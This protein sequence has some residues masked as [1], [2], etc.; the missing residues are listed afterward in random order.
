VN[1]QLPWLRI[2]DSALLSRHCRNTP[3]AL[4]GPGQI[5]VYAPDEDQDARWSQFSAEVLSG[6]FSTRDGLAQG[7]PDR[8]HWSMTYPLQPGPL[9]RFLGR[10]LE[11]YRFPELPPLDGPA[12][13]TFDFSVRREWV[14]GFALAPHSRDPQYATLVTRIAR[15]LQWAMRRWLPFLYFMEHPYEYQSRFV[16]PI[17][18]Y[19]A[20]TPRAV[21]KRREFGYEVLNKTLVAQA[22]RSASPRLRKVYRHFD[23]DRRTIDESSRSFLP[24]SSIEAALNYV[25][26]FPKQFERLI[27][28]DFFLIEQSIHFIET[29]R[30][31]RNSLDAPTN[32]LSRFFQTEV[33]GLARS[34]RRPLKRGLPANLEAYMPLLFI[35]AISALHGEGLGVDIPAATLTLRQGEWECGFANSPYTLDDELSFDGLSIPSVCA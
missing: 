26:R 25:W 8:L 19:A 2:L 33:E 32:T 3:L 6:T 34:L 9:P 31:L 16:L 12:E 20:S 30:R 29:A 35:Q 7:G 24:M 18:I 10:L 5:R 27:Q 14:E 28:F 1:V 13:L 17:L 22:I 4:D 11:D 15:T 21:K 23:P